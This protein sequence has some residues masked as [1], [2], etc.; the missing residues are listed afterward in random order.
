MNGA[1]PRADSEPENPRPDLLA[2][3]ESVGRK[4]R[5]EVEAASRYLRSVGRDD[6]ADRQE[7]CGDRWLTIMRTCPS[8]DE[9][10]VHGG[11]MCGGR[12][13]VVCHDRY[14]RKQRRK[15]LETLGS[16][17]WLGELVVTF[18]DRPWQDLYGRWR[19]R[20]DYGPEHFSYWAKRLAHAF[21]EWVAT[22][23]GGLLP[24]FIIWPHYRGKSDPR[25][26]HP[27]FNIIFAGLALD[28]EKR[29]LRELPNFACTEGVSRCQTAGA[30]HLNDGDLEDLKSW[31]C[32]AVD[33]PHHER[34]AG[35]F[36]VHAP[37]PETQRHR[38]RY[39]IRHP[40]EGEPGEADPAHR[41]MVTHR[42]QRWLR[43]G[44]AIAAGGGGKARRA[45]WLEL[46][47]PLPERAEVL[48]DGSCSSC[49]E[50]LHGGAS[51]G[52][53]PRGVLW[54]NVDGREYVKQLGKLSRVEKLRKLPED[55]PPTRVVGRQLKDE[56]HLAAAE[57]RAANRTRWLRVALDAW[58]TTLAEYSRELS[59]LYRER[60]DRLRKQLDYLYD[61]ASR[62]ELEELEA[63]AAVTALRKERPDHG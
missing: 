8:C 36:Y 27:H 40:A 46:R 41:W 12:G 20:E 38:I 52:L 15:V 3:A 26:S 18:P 25:K 31:L 47:P 54:L 9:T 45:L 7:A 6:E 42:Y 61:Y 10:N 29:E 35:P 63:R 13:C 23:T 55:R 51:V 56:L 2:S 39:V 37:T 49:E 53:G 62:L 19:T 60:R 32:L 1:S 17:P 59:G 24:A 28:E 58:R 22:R 33:L 11:G 43:S 4:I 34:G 48:L 57:K 14:P 21:E 50:P 44:G 30:G 5:R 16:Q